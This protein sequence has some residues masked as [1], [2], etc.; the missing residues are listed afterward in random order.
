M[1]M[2]GVDGFDWDDGN[3]GHCA[4]HGVS[5]R[6][7]ETLFLAT[8]MVTPDVSH[9]GIEERFNAVGQGVLGRMIFL[10]FTI[11]EIDGSRLIRPFNAR[12]MHKLE[13]RHYVETVPKA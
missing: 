5:R 10:T 12:Y 3:I 11:R 6:E 13:I 4:K 8:I 2:D 7:I 1:V 9:S